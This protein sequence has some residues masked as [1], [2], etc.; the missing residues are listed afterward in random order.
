[1]QL[2]LLHEPDLREPGD[3]EGANRHRTLLF[4][5]DLEDAWTDPGEADRR[6]DLER[7]RMTVLSCRYWLPETSE[8]A[9]RLGSR[10]PFLLFVRGD[11][12]HSAPRVAVVGTRHPDDYGLEMARCLGIALAR[13]GVTVVSGGA[14]GIDETAD[15]KSV[16]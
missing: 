7:E 12:R 15:R 13:A 5:R 11:L 10:A 2:K 8:L 14:I 16:V 1:M 4:P 3:S 6:L 9:A